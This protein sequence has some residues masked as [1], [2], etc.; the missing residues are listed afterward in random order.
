MTSTRSQVARSDDTPAARGARHS[1]SSPWPLLVIF[2]AALALFLP[3]SLMGVV[4]FDEGFIVTGAMQV[5]HGKLP[6][7]DFLSLYGP[8]QYYFIAGLFA[9]FGE[10][11]VVVHVAHAALLAGFAVTVFALARTAARRQRAVQVIIVLV[12]AGITLY[13]QPNVGY[14]A[15]SAGLLLLWATLAFGRWVDDQRWTTLSLASVLVGIA[16]VFRWDFGLFGLLAFAITIAALVPSRPRDLWR[17][18]RT[19][20]CAAGP[21]LAIMAAVYVPLLV[22]LSDPARWYHEILRYSLVEFPK[23]R[24]V[25]YLRPLYWALTTSLRTGDGALF[26]T[27]ALRL[28]YVALPASL[29]LATLAVVGVRLL[30]GRRALPDRASAQSLLLCLVALFL[31]HQ[32]R[33]RPHLWQGFP[34]V[35]ASL[36]LLAYVIDVIPA[37]LRSSWGLRTAGVVGGLILGGLLGHAAFTNGSHAIDGRAIALDTPRATGVRVDPEFAYYADLV[38]HVRSRTREGEAIYSGAQDHSRLYINDCMLYFL[39]GRPPADRFLELEPGISNTR[40]GQREIIASLRDKSVRVV[41]L[42]AI[43]S[44]EPNLTAV[45][46]GV[47]DLDT[48]L[49]EHYRPSMTFGPYTVLEA[50]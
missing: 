42:Y 22:V 28:A 23:W 31:L 3:P 8:G 20:V 21:A 27:S 11:L 45:S 14:A 10:R 44:N 43:D 5:L 47:H 46:N 33:V 38:N 1:G 40:A 32:M 4:T 36:P 50:K 48:F 13:V 41:V 35:V 16:G 19:G 34:G 7:R 29:I 12:F 26:S 49:A 37:R 15:T 17:V 9:V 39:T 18:V 2:L 30:R 25:E 24:N 6:Y